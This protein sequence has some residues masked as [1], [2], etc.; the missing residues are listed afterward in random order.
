MD[1]IPLLLVARLLDLVEVQS[2]VAAAL[3]GHT[4]LVPLEDP[5]L[6]EEKHALVVHAPGLPEPIV[7]NAVPAGEGSAGLF[8]LRLSPTRDDQVEMLRRLVGTKS[9][10]PPPTAARARSSARAPRSSRTPTP[11]KGKSRKTNP[12]LGGSTRP[13]RASRPDLEREDR[14]MPDARA[15]PLLGF[16]IGGGKYQIDT[17][18]GNG[19]YGRVYRGRHLRLSKPV[20]IKVLQGLMERDAD[21]AARFQRE[22]LAASKLDHP[23]V[24]QVV[25]YGEEPDGMLYIVME[26]LE[27]R[28]LRDAL[29]ETKPLPLPRIVELMTQLTA[30]LGAAHDLGVIHRDIKPENILLVTRRNDDGELKEQLKVCDFGIAA[31]Q[32]RG[33][34]GSQDYLSTGGTSVAG[35]PEYMAPEAARGETVDARS[36]IYACGV[37]MYELATGVVPFTAPTSVAVLVA[38]VSDAPRAPSQ[39]NLRLDMRLERLI[40]RTLSK[41]PND[42]PQTMRELRALLRVLLIGSS[43]QLRAV[44]KSTL[45]PPIPRE[46]EERSDLMPPPVA[47]R[48]PE[49]PASV[50]VRMP[51]DVHEPTLTL[52]PTRVPVFP[53]GAAARSDPPPQYAMDEPRAAVVV[54]ANAAPDLKSVPP[55]AE[56]AAPPRPLTDPTVG[57]AELLSAV[58]SAIARTTYYERAHPEFARSLAL[59]DTVMRDPL[60]RRGEITLARRERDTNELIVMTGAGEMLDLVKAAPGGIGA[61]CAQR[62]G[63]VFA[64]RGL[65]SLTFKEGLDER[66]L[67]DAVELLSGP[68]IAA[69]D[70]QAQFAARGLTRVSVL[71][72]TDMLG[73]DRR[74]PWQVLM[75]ISRIARDL[76]AVPKMVRASDPERRRTLRTAL[77]ADV[78]R[79][80]KT[81]EL[82]KSL[83]TSWELVCERVGEEAEMAPL[84]I[85]SLLVGSLAHPMLL[86]VASSVLAEME[87]QAVGP[88]HASSPPPGTSVRQLMQIVGNRFVRERTIESDEVLRE[89]HSRAVLSFPELPED[90]QL[91][92][93]AEQQAERLADD[94]ESVLRVLDSV[95]DLPRYARE[96]ATLARAMRVLARRAS[97]VALFAIVVRLEQRHARGAAPGDDTREGLAARALQSIA[98]AEVLD[99]IAI[100][101]LSGG[102]AMRDPAHGILVA[103]GREGARALCAVRE[104]GG[105]IVRMRFVEAMREIGNA[106]ATPL[107]A[108]VERLVLTPPDEDDAALAE[109]V[110]RALP[111]IPD[112]RTGLLVGQLL[113]HKSANV[114]RAAA[115]ALAS[116]WGQKARS[117]LF[118]AL[119]DPDESVR[120]AALTGLRKVGV[121]DVDVVR[122]AEKF[123]DGTA[124]AGDNACAVAAALLADAVPEA[125]D[126]AVQVLVTALTPRTRSVVARLTGA[127]T[128]PR[129]S[130]IVI[131]TLAR[132]LLAIG[133]PRGR[134]LVEKRAGKGPDDVQRRLQALLHGT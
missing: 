21:F 120:V 98:D 4:A 68:E 100:L 115:T 73:R 122:R 113:R 8:P 54:D 43:N 94:P 39:L 10:A 29:N 2:V 20:A 36:D 105:E 69:A 28:T 37:V 32:R 27:G 59:L 16:V 70:L 40:L 75:C 25:D 92:V 19:A 112:E 14:T 45:A 63:E 5:P 67:G 104:R 46:E 126:A 134:D 47:A 64:R 62:L 41:D 17:I 109:D 119:D 1:A 12:A 123:L 78:M 7:L 49:P 132:S 3:L 9:A 31:V 53:P 30:A 124:I 77:T 76:G 51:A 58:T 107:A 131:E 23:N 13:P 91:W 81:P 111:M 93:L 97:V 88:S 117:V 56:T 26:L 57:F 50:A 87:R 22:A 116:P 89:L 114:R 11:T 108:Q 24:A 85:P 66:E 18:I 96:T 84:D 83:L 80:L 60:E 79:T 34:G 110:L 127:P 65:V 35:T 102:G 130:P 74:L 71:F 90:V 125:R 38:H 48:A 118:G 42:R 86:R 121:I 99:P 15:D 44:R 72:V 95:F 6:S 133:G 101:L 33:D 106:A 82:V 103:C 61:G 128:S 55:A 52:P 129:E